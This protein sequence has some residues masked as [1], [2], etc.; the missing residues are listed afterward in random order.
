[1]AA[2]RA[3]H[4]EE[5]P[6]V[7]RF[8]RV[9]ARLLSG[10]IG[11]AFDQTVLPQHCRDLDTVQGLPDLGRFGGGAATTLSDLLRVL[12]IRSDER[13]VALPSRPTGD[14]RVVTAVAL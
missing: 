13:H 3:Q 7:C 2:R 14:R 9:E 11:I 12:R 8:A 1:M 6:D 5:L 10:G 4:L